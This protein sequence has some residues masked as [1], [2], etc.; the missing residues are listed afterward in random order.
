MLEPQYY[1]SRFVGIKQ[2]RVK[3]TYCNLLEPII[4]TATIQIHAYGHYIHMEN[5]C[6]EAR[7]QLSLTH[8]LTTTTHKSLSRSI[9]TNNMSGDVTANNSLKVHHTT[10]KITRHHR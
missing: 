4:K 2:S 1:F 7:A 8:S 5:T 3:R 6:I 10:D 9:Q